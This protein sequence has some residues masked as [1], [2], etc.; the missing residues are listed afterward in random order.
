[1]R[2]RREQREAAQHR[3]L[4][5]PSTQKHGAEKRL[6]VD[7]CSLCIGGECNCGKRGQS[8]SL[9]R[10]EQGADDPVEVTKAVKAMARLLCE[11]AGF[12]PD[13]GPKY[14]YG[15]INY[16][17][18]ARRALALANAFRPTPLH[19]D[20]KELAEGLAAKLEEIRKVPDSPDIALWVDMVTEMAEIAKEAL[21]DARTKGL[22]S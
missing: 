9:D 4:T 1:M 17:G 20:Y 18:Q 2:N 11:M 3:R 13:G 12:D 16:E 22:I 15:W 21:H 5:D 8:V 7:G 10:D 14:G 19:L 6:V